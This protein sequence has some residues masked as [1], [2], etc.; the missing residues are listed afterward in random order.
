MLKNVLRRTSRK[1]CN[2][3][4][5]QQP[6]LKKRCQTD[7]VSQLVRRPWLMSKTLARF[8]PVLGAG[9]HVEAPAAPVHPARLARADRGLASRHHGLPQ[10]EVERGFYPEPSYSLE[11]LKD[12]TPDMEKEQQ[13]HFGADMNGEG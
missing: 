3:V 1:L 2:P 4:S 12:K 6:G 5:I 11:H 7:T 10:A 9:G 8:S 13:E